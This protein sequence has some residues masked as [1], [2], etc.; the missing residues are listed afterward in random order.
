MVLYYIKINSSVDTRTVSYPPDVN[1]T[2]LTSLRPNTL[3]ALQLL[4]SNGAYNVSSET[5]TEETLDGGNY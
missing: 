5:V 1:S 3:Y 2:V 4:I